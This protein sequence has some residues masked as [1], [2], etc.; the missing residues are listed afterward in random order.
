MNKRQ[1]EIKLRAIHEE[2]VA[3]I[4]DETIQ[5]QVRNNSIVT[6][7][8]IASLLLGEKVNDYDYYFT[9]KETTLAVA[10]Y[11]ISQF[12]ET[13]DSIHNFKIKPPYVYT[14]KDG[15]KTEESDFDRIR[16]MIKSAGIAGTEEDTEDYDFFESRPMEVGEDYIQAAMKSVI[17]DADEIDSKEMESEEKFQPIFI[18]DNAITLSGNIQLVIRFFGNPKDLHEN[19]DFIHCT[20]YWTS[21]T[22]KLTLK[23]PALQSLLS[24]ELVYIGSKYPVS[25][26]IRIRKYLSRGWYINAGQILKVCLQLSEL[27]LT[28]IK[29]LE[30][31]LTG[32]DTAYFFDMI[33][34]LKEKQEQDA[35]FQPD[36]PYLVSI[37]DKIFG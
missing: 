36:M 4:K 27:D 32:V 13:Q 16:I 25:S 21:K 18:S 15:V 26:M 9:N 12:N 28:N 5:K 11:F 31:Q 14:E 3:S 35:E 29:V 24:K 23:L 30:D 8:S 17:E 22:R 33:R 20:N 10:K 6:G 1:A 7:G 37:I 2:F 19:F 34:K